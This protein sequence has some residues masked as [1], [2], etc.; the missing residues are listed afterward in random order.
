VT[1]AHAR[2]SAAK[3]ESGFQ[4]IAH[5]SCR[6]TSANGQGR[7]HGHVKKLK[8]RKAETLKSASRLVFYFPLFQIL[9]PLAFQ[10]FSF[11]VFSFF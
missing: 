1:C 5:R 8:E 3:H 10:F 2:S 11:L 9:G 4:A 6:I 7:Q